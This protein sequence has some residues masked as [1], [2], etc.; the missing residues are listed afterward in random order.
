VLDS[1]IN[2]ET[3][4]AKVN[5]YKTVELL[6]E[7]V[8]ED[9]LSL[10]Q[11]CIENHGSF[12]IALAGGGT[13]K[14]L[15]QLIASDA[16]RDKFPWEKIHVYFGDERCVPADHEDSNYRMANDALLTKVPIP[17]ENIHPIR[18]DVDDA[19]A[20]ADRYNDEL[21]ESLPSDQGTPK[22]DL[23]LLGL[24]DDGHTASLFPGTPILQ[25]MEKYADAV[26]V[27]KFSSW[28]ISITYPIINAAANIFLVT[29]GEGKARIVKTV[30][31][32]ELPAE[33]YPIQRIQ[34]QGNMYWYL[35]E[36][37]AAQAAEIVLGQA[38]VIKPT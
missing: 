31:F 7:T 28:R 5:V 14:K 32:D 15:Y 3:I 16:F 20:S 1:T 30:M 9:I 17:V 8:A 29:T 24:G 34:G 23:V 13:P 25:Q 33:P 26:Y 37:A 22:F 36:A 38:N 11:A 10:C 4:V 19:A 6:N 12:H 21:I 27:E 35:D 2:K 18:I